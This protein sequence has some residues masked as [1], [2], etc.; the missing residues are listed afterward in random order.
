M[1]KLVPILILLLLVC[2]GARA[3]TVSVM[4]K[5]GDIVNVREKPTTESAKVGWMEC[6]MS[7]ETDGVTKK[8][9]KGRT[10]VH[11]INAPL[12]VDEAWVCKMYV[13]DT[14]YIE[15]YDA[16]ITASGRVALRRAPG[17]SRIKWLSPGT[18]VK[19]VVRSDE[20]ALTTAGYIALDCLTAKGGA[21]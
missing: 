1:R 19:V 5:P 14:V 7:F 6:G 20:W 11:M 10:W 21:E 18:E 16:E 13:Q 12:E 9:S 3:D 8:D 15:S 4:C 2:G 17:G